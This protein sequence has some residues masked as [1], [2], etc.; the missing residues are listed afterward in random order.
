MKKQEFRKMKMV[1]EPLG[2]LQV[3]QHSYHGLLE[4]EREQDIENLYEKTSLI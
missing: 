3:Y 4:E 2:Q 1:M